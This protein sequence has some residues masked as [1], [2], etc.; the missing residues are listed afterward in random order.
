MR[1][2]HTPAL[3]LTLLFVT[4]L[5]YSCSNQPTSS[6]LNGADTVAV[7]EVKMADTTSFKKSNGE[8]CSIIADAT[9][10]YPTAYADKEMLK[11]LQHLYATAVLGAPDSLSLNEA[12]RLCVSNSMHQY[13]FTSPTAINDTEFDDEDTQPVSAYRTSSNIQVNYNKNGLVTFCRVDVV[14]KDSTVTSVTHHYCTIDLNKMAI[15]EL[16]DLFREDALAD[17]TQLLRQ[18]LLEQN[19][20][21]NSDQLNELG[22]YN[23]DN[24]MATNNFCFDNTGITWSYQPNELAVNAVGEP[25]I[26]LDYELLTPLAC[27]GSVIDRVK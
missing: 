12:M 22:Y 1:I 21:Q 14:K 7:A 15:V 3:L 26:T 20:V 4:A 13:D 6:T 2:I 8:L 16:K 5:S 24:L 17:V 11:Q 10:N 25:R 27:E 9:F 23:I 18:R 19:N